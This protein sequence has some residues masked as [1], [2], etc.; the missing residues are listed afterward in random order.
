MAEPRIV[1]TTVADEP[2]AMEMAS[3]LVERRLAACVNI[4]GPIR[5]VYRWKGKLER[6]TE[7]LLVIKT[8]AD[9]AARLETAF[10][11]LHPYELPERVELSVEG[12]SEEYLAW[13]SGEV[14]EE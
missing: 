2:K 1:L 14:R 3:A 13:I 11:E 7:F 8:T 10:E 9:Q 4:V 6:E 5:S 12:G